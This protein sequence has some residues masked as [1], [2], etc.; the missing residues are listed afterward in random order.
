MRTQDCFGSSSSFPLFLCAFLYF[1]HCSVPSRFPSAPQSFSKSFFQLFRLVSLAWAFSTITSPTFMSLPA[2]VTPQ[3]M[4]LLNSLFVVMA[5]D[6]HNHHCPACSGVFLPLCLFLDYKCYINLRLKMRLPSS[7]LHLCLTPPQSGAF[8]S[9]V[10]NIPPKPMF[11][12]GNL[13]WKLVKL[14]N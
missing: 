2:L 14:F 6:M 5:V 8:Y 4:L 10:E 12:A 3:I 1:F 7:C 13:R 11:P 9:F